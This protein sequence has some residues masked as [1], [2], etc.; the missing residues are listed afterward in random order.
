[1]LRK[2]ATNLFVAIEGEFCRDGKFCGLESPKQGL[3][4]MY[5]DLPG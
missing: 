3:N 5:W 4:V 1:M 2:V